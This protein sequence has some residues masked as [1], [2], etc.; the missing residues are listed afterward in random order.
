VNH[1][2]TAPTPGQDVPDTDV[3]AQNEQAAILDFS[4]FDLVDIGRQAYEDSTTYFDIK[5]R[6]VLGHNYALA[7]SRHPPGSKYYTDKYKY[8]SKVFRSK[9]EAAIQRNES[10]LAVALFSTG[11]VLKVEAQYEDN[12]DQENAAELLNS[13]INYHFTTDVPWFQTCLGAFNEAQTAGYVCS[14]QS[15]QYDPGDTPTTWGDAAEYKP[16]INSPCV[17]LI[18]PENL[19]LHPACDW[20][21]PVNSSP[22]VIVL[23]PMYVQDIKARMADDW[24]KADDSVII[25][26][27]DMQ[28][29][30]IRLQREGDPVVD[31]KDQGS[32]VREF[33]IAWVREIFMDLEGVEIVYYM[34]GDEH[35]LAEPIPLKEAYPHCKDNKRPFSFGTTSI[36]PHKPYSKGLPARVEGSQVQANE[37]ANQRF[38][39]VQLVLNKR[40]FVRNHANVDMRSLMRNVPGSV[41]LMDDVTAVQL[42]DIPDVTASSYR[43]QAMINMDFDEIAGT[44]STSS[45]GSNRQLNETVGGM[46]LLAGNANQLTE[47]QLRIFV[48]TWVEPVMRQVVA[49]VQTYES[50]EAIKEITG[51]EDANNQMLNTLVIPRVNV[52]F[53]ATDPQQRVGR[54]MMGLSSIGKVSPEAIQNLDVSEV[55]KEV[56]GSVGYR[57]GKRFF[58]KDKEGQG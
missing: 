32:S 21:D 53:G 22:Y 1:N 30:S 34:L 44:F 5:L 57:D 43:E 7:D 13:L 18:P 20:I 11:D 28:N 10:A 37:I 33:D 38:D 15:W 14:K 47:Y 42:E 3:G 41:T 23:Y 46:K 25:A 52:G 31:S 4:G 16:V 6:K 58:L 48:E 26:A 27:G 17:E 45:V 12:K 49:M 39:N 8:R 9:T 29:D 55:I 19:R 2:R 51:R 35:I 36:Q 50:D 40:Y 54:L 56:F 24:I